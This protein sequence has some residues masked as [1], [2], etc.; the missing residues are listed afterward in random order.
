MHILLYISKVNEKEMSNSTKMWK[1]SHIVFQNLIL[2]YFL[3]VFNFHSQN[4]K[5]DIYNWEK[6]SWPFSLCSNIIKF[7]YKYWRKKIYALWIAHICIC[8]SKKVVLILFFIF[9]FNISGDRWA[10]CHIRWKNML[11]QFILLFNSFD[12]FSFHPIQIPPPI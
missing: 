2:S 10:N 1:I 6:E 5:H 11:F 9:F 8:G 7:I 12:F 4:M 3:H